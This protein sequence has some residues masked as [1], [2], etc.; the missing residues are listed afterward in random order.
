MKIETKFDI[1]QEVYYINPNHPSDVYC[2]Y[3][4]EIKFDGEHVWYQIGYYGDWFIGVWATK[5]EV[6]EI[7]EEQDVED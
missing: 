5:K 2:G 1:G 4:N 7:L 3:I 6:E